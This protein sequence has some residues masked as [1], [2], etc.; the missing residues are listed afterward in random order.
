MTL[1]AGEAETHSGAQRAA[2]MTP[3]AE[4]PEWVGLAEANEARVYEALVHGAD[5]AHF[6]VARQGS[7]RLLFGRGS[8]SQLVVNRVIGWGIVEPPSEA[9]LDRIVQAYGRAGFGIELAGRAATADVVAWLRARGLRRVSTAQVMVR[10]AA[11]PPSMYDAWEARTGL[12]VQRVGAEGLPT[13]ARLSC[14]NFNVPA[15]VGVLLAAGTLGPGWRRWLA[16]DGEQAIGSSLSYVEGDVAWFGWTCVAP[17]HRGKWLHS[18]F[19]AR[20]LEEAAAAGCRWITTESALSTPQKPDPV[21]HNLR[22]FGFFDAYL[23]PIYV[24]PPVR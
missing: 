12:R 22:R 5:L 3:A 11:D 16:F 13:L 1:M 9:S 7:A 19:L 10:P 18:A 23:R 17:S 4:T 20:Q 2:E 6:E 14:E 21:H 8:P 24:R 15:A